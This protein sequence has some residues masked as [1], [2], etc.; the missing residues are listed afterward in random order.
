MMLFPHSKAIALAT[1]IKMNT[2]K[3]LMIGER[4]YNIERLYNIR[5][6]LTYKDDSLPDRLVKAPQDQ[7]NPKSVVNLDVMLPVYYECRNWDKEG[8]P[9]KKIIER[10]GI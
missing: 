6:G 10:L 2:A 9:T 8:I 7:N 5:E 4:G 1:G 3:F